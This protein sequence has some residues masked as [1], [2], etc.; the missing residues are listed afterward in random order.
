MQVFERIDASGERGEN[1]LKGKEF[2]KKLRGSFYFL[3]LI[4]TAKYWLLENMVKSAIKS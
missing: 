3:Q 4:L 2:L 1:R